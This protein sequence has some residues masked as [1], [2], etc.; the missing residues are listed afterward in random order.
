[1]VNRCESLINVVNA[2]KPKMLIG[3]NQN[4]KWPSTAVRTSAVA[5]EAP[6]AERQDLTHTGSHTE[7]DKPVVLPKLGK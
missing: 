5:D 3:L 2:N 4:G 6:P 1:M 7:R